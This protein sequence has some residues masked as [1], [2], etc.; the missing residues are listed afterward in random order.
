LEKDGDLRAAFQGLGDEASVDG[1]DTDLVWRAVSGELPPDERREVVDRVA[2]DPSWALAWRVAH[3][4]RSALPKSRSRPG[5]RLVWSRGARY[6]ALAAG[7]IAAT[8]AGLWFRQPA[9]PPGYREQTGARIESLVPERQALPRQRCV[10]RWTGPPGATYEVRATSEDLLLVH[11]APGLI[12]REYRVPEE[13]LS[14]FPPGAKVL[15]RVEGRLP[16][17]TV[18]AGPTFVARLE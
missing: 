13:F 9:P 7:L 18:L 3:E 17:G 14:A 2:R 15:W 6:G 1:V 16:D 10:L 8:A 4:L 5:L 11:T 12:E